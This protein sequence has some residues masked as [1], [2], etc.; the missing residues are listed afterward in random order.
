[1]PSQSATVTRHGNLDGTR[2][3]RKNPA[4]ADDELLTLDF[5]AAH[6]GE[7]FEVEIEGRAPYRLE[8]TEAEGVAGDSDARA[9]FSLIFRA[10]ADEPMLEQRIYRLTHAGLE[11]LDLFLVPVGPA[12][13]DGRLLYEAAFS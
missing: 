8:L 11:P 3:R 5:F 12:R 7:F 6:V 2:N 1:M 4:M 10:G 9:P 13:G